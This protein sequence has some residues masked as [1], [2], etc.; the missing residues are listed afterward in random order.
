MSD[1]ILM[2]VHQEDSNPGLVGHVLTEMGY[3]LDIRCPALGDELPP[4]MDHHRG[5][6]IFGGPMS[7]NDDDALPFIRTELDWI[8]IAL[9]AK[10]PFLG[11]C[12]GA[13][14]LARSL[15]AKVETHPNDTVEIG[16]FPIAP[17]ADGHD[18]FATLPQVYHWHR[19]GFDLPSAAVLLATG[20]TFP[21]QA[22]HY[23]G[24][25]FGLQFHPEM[26]ADLM[27]H[28]TTNGHEHLGRDGAQSREEQFRNHT[29]YSAYVDR[30][31]RR[32]LDQWLESSTCLTSTAMS[33]Y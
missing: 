28:W 31:L 3:Q 7:A 30:W 19:E 29:R 6:V 17:T 9:E 24:H 26:T 2:I 15:G 1:S 20:Q 32:F 33:E 23:G 4:F 22:F 11:I 12:L 18:L 13:Q 21:H 25:A 14:L 10:R 5:V 16:Y 27:E 8:P